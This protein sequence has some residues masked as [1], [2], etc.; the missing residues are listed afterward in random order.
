MLKS[1]IVKATTKIFY[2][3]GFAPLAIQGLPRVHEDFAIIKYL[4][5]FAKH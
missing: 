2:Y 5:N 4:F 1:G 3:E